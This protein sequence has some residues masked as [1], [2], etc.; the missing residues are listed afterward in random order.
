MQGKED[1]ILLTKLKKGNRLAF[2]TLYKKYFAVLYGF[3]L[4]LTNNQTDAEEVVQ[5]VFIKL[6]EIKRTL[7]NKKNFK[8]LLFTI[9]KNKIYNR[10]R[11]RVYEHAYQNY[12]QQQNNF[13]EF[14]IDREV[15]YLET[16]SFIDKGIELLPSR[17]KEI[18]ILSRM[19]GMS[20]KEIAM[21]M[22]T[23]TSNI[24]NHIN[25]ALKSL[26]KYMINHEII[27]WGLPFII[28]SIIFNSF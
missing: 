21:K 22:N 8:S 10:S 15:S 27:F 25:K 11:Q 24:E 7:D 26:K 13:T 28:K 16:K 4:K 14:T 23:S 18:F 3:T 2:N 5:E 6:W 1:Q 12:L 20:N 19:Q 9:A 17:R